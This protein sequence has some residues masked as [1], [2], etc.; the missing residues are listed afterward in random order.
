MGQ[1]L[2][3][4]LVMFGSAWHLL[5]Q[6]ETTVP[7]GVQRTWMDTSVKPCV[8]FFRYANGAWLQ[9]VP[10][11]EDMPVW[12]TPMEIEERNQKIVKKILD[13]TAS[14]QNWPKGSPQQQVGDFYLSGMDTAAIEKAGVNPLASRF[15]RI[16]K[17]RSIAG[18]AGMLAFLHREGTFSGFN[19]LVDADEKQ[20]SRVIAQ[21]SQGGLTLPNLDTYLGQEEGARTLRAQFEAY[22]TRMFRLLGETDTRAKASAAA[23]LDIETRLT[24]ASMTGGDL[25][26]PNADYHRMTRSQL[27][28]VAPGFPWDIYFQELELPE[29][30]Q[31]LLV[32][33]PT[34]F[35]QFAAMAASVPLSSWRAYLRWQLLQTHAG[36]LSQTF[37]NESFAFRGGVL[38]GIKEQQPRWK[39]VADAT[40][41]ALGEPLGK[42]FV[43]RTFPPATK[44]K[45]L[46]MVENI[47][48]VLRERISALE[49][50]TPATKARALAKLESLCVK[51][52]YPD[53][54][55][56]TSG[57]EIKRQPY[58]LNVVAA[59]Q[60]RHRVALATLGRPLDR[61]VWS[62]APSGMFAY[63]W[64]PTNEI[65]FPAG[66][67]Q[68]PVFDP[69][70]DDALNYGG[71]GVLIGH[72]LTHG[73]DD[74]GR[75]YDGEGN[76]TDWWAPEDA[77]AFEE[78]ARLMVD[79]YASYHPAPGLTTNG[80]R[81]LGENLADLGGVTLAFEAY[82][83]TLP[84]NAPAAGSDGFTPEQRFFV[85]FA[86]GYFRRLLRPEYL[87]LLW[88]VD[89]HAPPE[90][91]VNGPLSCLSAF[92]E[93]FACSPGDALSLPADKRPSIW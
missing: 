14:R 68:P 22:V 65:C 15:K 51:I 67:L 81:V 87:R 27:H 79:L 89:S 29:S 74:N 60:F 64:A 77:K 88:E 16:A 24:R 59:A 76:L 25:R 31:E 80:E 13:E 85:A 26:N 52:A 28:R 72:E 54:W 23:V 4:L 3:F 20:N 12:G 46:A 56:D 70:G 66:I 18:L 63:Y 19:F 82:R 39:R 33:Q 42:L 69:N 90:Y 75:R 47:L 21:L 62:A 71:I 9:S 2:V 53:Q 38:Q 92:S 35:T 57:L 93:A 8:D 41:A 11:P 55:Q 30:E 34:F 5:A 6:G 10:I 61:K 45:A 17:I 86:Q 48:A 44:Q 83:K 37:A 32:R 7:R 40:E 36:K 84:K 58:V 91:R 73:F 49:W 50:M 1:R 43:D 78:R